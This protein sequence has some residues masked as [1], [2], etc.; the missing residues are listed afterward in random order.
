MESKSYSFADEMEDEI[1]ES[2]N[3]QNEVVNEFEKNNLN[4][5]SSAFLDL[6]FI[7]TFTNR[8]DVSEPK[9]NKN[10]NDLHLNNSIDHLLFKN[11]NDIKIDNY[12]DMLEDESYE[13]DYMDIN[14][15]K[16]VENRNDATKIINDVLGEESS[17]D[18]YK[19]PLGLWGSDDDLTS[20]SSQVTRD[21]VIGRGVIGKKTD[22]GNETY[23]GPSK[24]KPSK[25]KTTIEEIDSLDN[26]MELSPPIMIRNPEM[27]G[28]IYSKGFESDLIDNYL[29]GDVLFSNK[30]IGEVESLN[31]R[32]YKRIIKRREERRFIEDRRIR[33]SGPYKYK[34]RH[35]H[36]VKR[37]RGP[38][39]KF[40]TKEELKLI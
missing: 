7:K 8:N 20:N 14:E 2:I 33:I 30:G 4:V 29:K 32:Q 5:F 27:L 22:T 39:G 35:D 36:A 25:T 40:L 12:K 17:D 10:K 38:G 11:I 34:S 23:N 37:S 26:Q 19:T 24:T 15:N 18:Y 1:S 31:P 6:P 21:D 9:R 28:N 3:G 13:T 16:L